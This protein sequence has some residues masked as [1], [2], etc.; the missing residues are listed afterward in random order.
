MQFPPCYLII[1]IWL[2]EWNSIQFVIK[3]A[4]G[5]IV[6][7]HTQNRQQKIL[8]RADVIYNDFKLSSIR[9]LCLYR[10]KT[11]P[12]S[13]RHHVLQ[14]AGGSIVTSFLPNTQLY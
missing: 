8:C 5:Q 3:D 9:T 10:V 6:G 1:H 12:V 4:K 7:K 11:Q 13:T 2:I 14:T